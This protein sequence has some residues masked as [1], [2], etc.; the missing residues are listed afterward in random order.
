MEKKKVLKKFK[1]FT[2]IFE[3]WDSWLK[4]NN[5]KPIEACWNYVARY[6]HINNYVIGFHELKQ[7]EEIYNIKLKYIKFPI[8]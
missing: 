7:I 3:K 8:S 6:K 1:S 4:Y 2:K 5:I